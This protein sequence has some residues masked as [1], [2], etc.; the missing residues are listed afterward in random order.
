MS[1]N[2]SGLLGDILSVGI[3]GWMGILDPV[4]LIISGIS[5]VVDLVGLIK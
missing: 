1:G 2:L 3:A 5:A 4:F